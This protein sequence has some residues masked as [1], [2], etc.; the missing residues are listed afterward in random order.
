[1]TLTAANIYVSVQTASTVIS[2]VTLSSYSA[3]LGVTNSNI[4]SAVTLTAA[5]I[6]GSVRTVSTAVSAV[7]LTAQDVSI[8]GILSSGAGILA[9]SLSSR[10]ITL[11]HTPA[12]DGTNARLDIGEFDTVTAGNQGFSGFSVEYN[13]IN[14]KLVTQSTFAGSATLTATTMDRFGTIE[15][16]NGWYISSV[17]QVSAI[18]INQATAGPIYTT[19]T[20][21]TGTGAGLG[22]LILPQT[23]GGHILYIYNY[24]T[25]S[26]SANANI[27]PQT[28]GRIAGLATNSPFVVSNNSG[29]L[30]QSL[31]TN[32]WI[33]AGIV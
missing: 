24:S 33:G 21:I 9:N 28:G 30:I 10:F 31:S 23:S 17:S 6:Y 22:G 3:Y 13:E 1:V 26:G 20:T 25:G 8:Y 29:A 7:T 32:L 5:N 11:V 15:Q 18:G 27:Y 4:I 19:V 12:N 2:A 14:N 16:P